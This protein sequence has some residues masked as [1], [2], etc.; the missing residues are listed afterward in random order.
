ML[1]LCLAAFGTLR[2][3]DS[4][5]SGMAASTVVVVHKGESFRDIARNLKRLGLIKSALLLDG[6]SVLTHTASALQ[7]GRYSIDKGSSTIAIHDML[8]SGRQILVRVTIPEGWT[9]RQIAARL[10]AQKITTASAFLD[11]A[12]S[13]PLLKALHIPL[14]SAQGFLFPDTYL[15]PE[16]YPAD[17]VVRTMAADFFKNL[18]EI[19]PEYA[20]LPPSDLAA[21]VTMASVV[22][23]E[24]RVPDEAPVIASVFYNRLA[25]NIRLESC[26]T[27]SYVLT[28]I[29][30]K[31]HQTR[32]YD[33]DLWV[34]SP[35]NTYRH[36]GLPPGPISEPGRTALHA[37]FYPAK[38]N[39]LYF[40]LE[41]P[42]SGKHF[43]SESYS[44][45]ELAKYEYV[46]LY[47][48]Q[49]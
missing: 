19:Y 16:G 30:G 15:F 40:V 28:D 7:V 17:K 12:G 21:K 11:A 37:A 25:A 9:L 39:F 20:S 14:R 33:K 46:N 47:L 6:Y 41:N 38:T 27:V 42:V 10:E 49:N 31:P 1:A 43:F 45:H 24:Y 18:S 48:K 4:A 3:L 2:W 44:A 29:E 26:A 13:A 23:G 36:R 34:S 32:L 35:Y 22:E 8:V 5:P